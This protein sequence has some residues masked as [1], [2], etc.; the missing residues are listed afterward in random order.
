MTSIRNPRLRVPLLLAN[1]GAVAA[2]NAIGGQGGT[3]VQAAVLAI[4]WRPAG[5]RGA[6][7]TATTARWPA[8]GPMSGRR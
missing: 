8:A 7:A 4:P 3:A 2:V 5:T 1:G 6:G